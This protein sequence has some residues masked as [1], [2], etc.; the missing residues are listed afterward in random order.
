VDSLDDR[1]GFRNPYNGLLAFEVA[2]TLVP[3]KPLSNL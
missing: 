1:K 3:D 2:R